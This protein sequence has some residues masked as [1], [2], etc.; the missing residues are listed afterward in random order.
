MAPPLTHILVPLPFHLSQIIHH[1]RG[2]MINI[3]MIDNGPDE[4]KQ[5]EPHAETDHGQPEG[6]LHR[7][8]IQFGQFE[9]GGRDDQLGNGRDEPAEI[10]M[11]RRDA[12]VA[13]NAEHDPERE[14]PERKGPEE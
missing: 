9:P 1:K 11:G 10:G 13:E 6:K 14:N 3:A 12:L 7:L 2:L 8:G 5:K 4:E